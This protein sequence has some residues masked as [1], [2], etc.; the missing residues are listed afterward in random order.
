MKRHTQSMRTGVAAA[1]EDLVTVPATV[2]PSQVERHVHV[3]NEVDKELERFRRAVVVRGRALASILS[4]DAGH[5]PNRAEYVC[6]LLAGPVSRSRECT[7]ST[8][9]CLVS[10]VASRHA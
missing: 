10:G 7:R 9:W 1:K 5:V 6:A 3:A 2:A 4:E 8:S